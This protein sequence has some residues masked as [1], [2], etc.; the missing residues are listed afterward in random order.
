[1]FRNN[2]HVSV[3]L[4]VDIAWQI[5]FIFAVELSAAMASM[6]CIIAGQVLGTGDAWKNAPPETRARMSSYLLTPRRAENMSEI[7][8][9]S[10]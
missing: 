9:I 8:I 10:P 7:I 2:S 1:M 3:D 5:I 4:R 6:P